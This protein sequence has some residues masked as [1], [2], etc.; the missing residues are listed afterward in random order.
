MSANAIKVEIAPG[1]LIDKITILDIKSERIDDPDKLK[2]VRPRK[3]P[4]RPP[5]NWTN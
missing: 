1:E 5:L 4:C 2:N 3:I